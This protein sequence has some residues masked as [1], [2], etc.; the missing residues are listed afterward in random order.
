MEL[1]PVKGHDRNAPA[2]SGTR[3][4]IAIA[5]TAGCSH[6]AAANQRVGNNVNTTPRSPTQTLSPICND[7][8]RQPQFAGGQ[9]DH[10]STSSLA[11]TAPQVIGILIVAVDGIGYS[12]NASESSVTAP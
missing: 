4:A 10:P 8:T 7:L 6:A 9:A 1:T 11:T 3:I 12:P 5:P 2:A